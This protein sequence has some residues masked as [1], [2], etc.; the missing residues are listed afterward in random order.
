MPGEERHVL[1][2]KLGEHLFLRLGNHRV[3]DLRQRH[4]LEIAG[5]AFGRVE[6]DHQRRQPD[7]RGGV[8]VDEDLVDHVLHQPGAEGGHA[9]DDP[10]EEESGRV[11]GRVAAPF[12]PEQPAQH[13]LVVHG[14]DECEKF[15]MARLT[16]AC[17]C[18]PSQR[19]I[20]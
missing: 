4:L 9:G 15:H 20:L 14:E 13:P 3:A 2:Q 5:D 16:R 6:P 17:P 7:D 8:P 19:A 18:S 12:L 10:H 11:A 1:P